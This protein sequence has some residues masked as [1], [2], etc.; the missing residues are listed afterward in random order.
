MLSSMSQACGHRQHLSKE[1]VQEE[2]NLSNHSS[3]SYLAR[4]AFDSHRYADVIEFLE[5]LLLNSGKREF[6]NRSMWQYGN[7][8]IP[9]LGR[10]QHS[11][12]R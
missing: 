10:S 12:G 6:I 2:M 8:L 4:E 9:F 11:E 7:V 5:P 3:K 1:L